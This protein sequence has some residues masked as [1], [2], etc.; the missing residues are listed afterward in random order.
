MSRGVHFSRCCTYAEAVS[1]ITVHTN[2]ICIVKLAKQR[3]HVKVIYLFS[4]VREHRKESTERAK[5]LVVCSENVLG[6]CSKPATN[7]FALAN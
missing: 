6:R 4:F 5:A 3:R 1:K 2:K 7:A